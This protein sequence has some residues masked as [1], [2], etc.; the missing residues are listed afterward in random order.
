MLSS[1]DSMVWCEMIAPF[2]LP[3]VPLVKQMV[4]TSC[5]A[6]ARAGRTDSHYT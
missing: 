1:S 5:G 3:I 2:G 6:G 4:H